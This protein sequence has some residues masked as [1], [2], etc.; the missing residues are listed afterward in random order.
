MRGLVVLAGAALDL[1]LFGQHG[2]EVGIDSHE[3]ASLA[4]RVVV[5]GRR[6]LGRLLTGL[7]GL[8]GL[9]GHTG[10]PLV[11]TAPAATGGDDPAGTAPAAGL[12]HNH[13][14][15]AGNLV[16][17][18]DLVGKDLAL[19]DPHLDAD[20]ALGRLG[21]AEAVVD[22]SAEGV[23]R[24]AA[25]AVE[26]LA[27]HLRSTEATRAL[28]PDALGTRLLHR[29]HGPLHGPA[30]A[31]ATGQ[32]VGDALGDQGGVELGLLDL[33]D[34]ELDLGVAGDV[35][36]LGPQ[37]VG[38]GAAAADHDAGAGGVDVDPQAIPGALHLDAADRGAL[39]LAHEV[40]PDL[41]VLDHP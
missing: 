18:R 5:S 38:F 39:Q 4:T 15:F 23:Q 28:H 37:P 36:Q 3:G 6:G 14:R 21:L 17:G 11:G 7:A 1:F 32:L 40:V 35:G 16:L 8:A 33:L 31:H 12:A 2:L 9:A 20:A 26:L 25:L 19:V 24:H 27:A 13:R 41:P 10:L 30:E 34:V 22:V 29:L